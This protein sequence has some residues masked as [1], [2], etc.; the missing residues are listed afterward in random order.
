MSA[1]VRP[2]TAFVVFA[3]HPSRESKQLGL[4]KRR[5][6]SVFSTMLQRTL[7]VVRAAGQADHLFIV[8]ERIA[9]QGF[10]AISQRQGDFETRL[11]AAYQDVFALGYQRVV[12]VGSDTPSLSV[13]DLRRAAATNTVSVGPSTDGGLYLLALER[14]D[15]DQLKDLPWQTPAL[16]DAVELRFCRRGIQWGLQRADIDDQSDLIG[17]SA[18]ERSVLG[19][20]PTCQLGPVWSRRQ[21]PYRAAPLVREAPGLAPPLT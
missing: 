6:G 15:I 2:R 16:I 7:R 19:L 1:D 17:L 14:E 8:G 9:A 21:R 3:R 20:E 5:D 4:G 11:R 12:L 18:R 10:K 13:S